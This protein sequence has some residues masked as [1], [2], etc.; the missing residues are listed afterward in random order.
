MPK[1]TAER[2]RNKY[3]NSRIGFSMNISISKDTLRKREK[4]NSMTDAERQA[5]GQNDRERIAEL[6]LL[7]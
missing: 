5:M 2:N 6:K 1:S 3:K 4:R 7:R